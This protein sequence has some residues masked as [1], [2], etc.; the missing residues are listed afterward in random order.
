MSFFMTTSRSWGVLLPRWPA[1]ESLHLAEGVSPFFDPQGFWDVCLPLVLALWAMGAVFWAMEKQ[2]MAGLDEAGLEADEEVV[3]RKGGRRVTHVFI[4]GVVGRVLL[5]LLPFAPYPF[6]RTRWDWVL[7][8]PTIFETL[9]H[10]YH[11]HDTS[12][13]LKWSLLGH[14]AAVLLVVWPLARCVRARLH[15]HRTGMQMLPHPGR[16]STRLTRMLRRLTE[17]VPY[18]VSALSMPLFFE[19]GSAWSYLSYLVKTRGPRVLDALGLHKVSSVP[20]ALCSRRE[21]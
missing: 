19:V 18:P 12:A 3:A 13:K 10:L 2:L 8:A 16:Q 20:A 11:W 9:A 4:T 17:A 1:D 7:T 14:H 15:T 6:L 5:L 21:R